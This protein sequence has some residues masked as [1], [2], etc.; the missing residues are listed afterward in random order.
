MQE[1]ISFGTWLRRQRR[2]L[3]LTRQAFAAQVGCAEVT[4]RRIEAGTLKPSKELASLLLEKVGIPRTERSRW[5]SFARGLSGLPGGSTPASNKPVTNLPAPLTSFIGREKELADVRKLIARHRLVTLTGPGGVGKTRLSVKVGELVLA[6]FPEGVWMVELAPVLDP[7]L[8]PATAARTFGLLE[9]PK[10]PFIDVLCDFLREKTLLL[11]LDNC[12][13][14]LDACAQFAD[15]ALKRCPNLKVL[16]T[17]REV[18]GVLGEAVYPVPSL[19]LPNIRHL[20]D[21]FREFESIRLFEERAQLAQV[22]FSLTIGNAPAVAKVCTQLDGI[23][24][25]IELAAARINTF[26][27]E[28]IAERLPRNFRLLS[29]GNRT[30]LPRHRTLHAAIDWS[31]DLLSTDEKILFRRLSVFVDSWTLEA[32]ESVCSDAHIHSELFFDL[33]TRLLTKSLITKEVTQVGT[34]YRML[35]TLRQYAYEKLWAMDEANIISQRHLAYFVSLAD[36][37]EPHL[38]S[39]DAEKWLEVLEKELDNIRSALAYGLKNDVEAELRLASALWWFWHIRGHKSEGWEWLEQGLAIEEQERGA[40]RRLSARTLIRGKALYVAGFLRLMFFE[41]DKG[42]SLSEES[43]S[44]FRGLGEEGKR[45]AAYALWNLGGAASRQLDFHHA[46]LLF[47][48]SL[49]LFQEVKDQFGIAQCMDALPFLQMHENKYEE[50]RVLLE[51]HLALRQ[52]IGDKDG[53]ATAFH[54]LGLLAFQQNN[55]KEAGVHFRASLDLYRRIGNRWGMGHALSSLG[56]TA[57]S[58][59][60]YEEAT[61]ILEEALALDQDVGDRFGIASRLNELG[62]VAQSRGDYE[63]AVQMHEQALELLFE[64]G[65][66]ASASVVIF[67]LGSIALLR[68][69]DQQAAR[70]FE[71]ALTISQEAGDP[72][73]TAWVFYGMGELARSQGDFKTARAHNLEALAIFRKVGFHTLLIHRAQGLVAYCLEAS[74]CL[75]FAQKQMERAIRLFSVS[76]KL[77]PPLRFEMP[78]ARRSEHDQAILSAR[79]ASGEDSFATTWRL[80]E[81][82]TVDEA[83]RYGLE[84]T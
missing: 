5:V 78:A 38:R 9:D 57:Q 50:A 45:G 77:Y 43:L 2:A 55:Y 83:V 64:A 44:L 16:T 35:E 49:A 32:A 28:E 84:E 82:M 61:E 53:M 19:A 59:G 36:R 34:R 74:A 72:L 14:V 56:R 70:N 46:K 13:H 26:S 18:F 10:R 27:A 81:A 3:D 60:N 58:E 21:R 11:I 76:E 42:A 66:R 4:L 8:V 23:P 25:A 51:E 20:V 79:R 33:L 41:T 24:L 73:G 29:T 39:F 65:D 67:H 71:E 40:N 68:S 47:E 75:A 80:G 22:N 54:H 69:D 30:A 15:T 7:S 52:E 37:A 17:S 1:E 63:R 62:L 12:E 48:E 6:D 31:Y